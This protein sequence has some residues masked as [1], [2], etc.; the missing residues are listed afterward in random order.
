M[1]ESTFSGVTSVEV[2]G[3]APPGVQTHTVFTGNMFMKSLFMATAADLGI[4]SSFAVNNGFVVCSMTTGTVQLCCVCALL[5]LSHCSRGL[6]FVA[7]NAILSKDRRG[8][9]KGQANQ[10]EQTKKTTH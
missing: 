9:T 10:A 8:Y 1:T 3:T 6:F 7:L 4:N 2:A 5:P